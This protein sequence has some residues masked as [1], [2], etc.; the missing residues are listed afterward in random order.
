MNYV[1][2]STG[3]VVDRRLEEGKTVDQDGKSYV[4][5]SGTLACENFETLL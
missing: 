4:V 5:I 3:T 1:C 2:A